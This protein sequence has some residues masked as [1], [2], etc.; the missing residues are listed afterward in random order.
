M[1]ALSVIRKG[2]ANRKELSLSRGGKF[3]SFIVNTQ[4]DP[5]SPPP[6]VPQRR[7]LEAGEGKG[8]EHH[9]WQALPELFSDKSG[10]MLGGNEN[11]QKLINREN[12]RSCFRIW[13]RMRL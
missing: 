3:F 2:Q 1:S 12:L 4:F 10:F 13:K 8:E 7:M 5:L 6:L 11:K 9:T